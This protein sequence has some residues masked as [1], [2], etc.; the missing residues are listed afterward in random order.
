V[1]ADEFLILTFAFS[2]GISL[3]S[4]TDPFI[5]DL[6]CGLTISAAKKNNQR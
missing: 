1:P 6:S 4:V 3:P 5:T 2:T